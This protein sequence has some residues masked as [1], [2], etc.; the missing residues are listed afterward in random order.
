MLYMQ[1]SKMIISPGS[2]NFEICAKKKQNTYHP[3]NTSQSQY[4]SGLPEGSFQT[5]T[6]RQYI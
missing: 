5:N 2:A 6:Y 1:R 3:W 4:L